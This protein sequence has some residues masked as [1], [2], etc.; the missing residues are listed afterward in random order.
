MPLGTEPVGKT[1]VTVGFDDTQL[2]QGLTNL[3]A[4][5]KLADNTWK[6]SLSTF[7]QSDRSIEKLSTSV[8]GMTDKLEI[9][10]KIVDAHK[11][12]VA[13]LTKEYG[14]NHTKVIKANA[15][16]AKQQGVYG[17]LKRSINEMTAEMK[18]QTIEQKKAEGQQA[19]LLKQEQEMA[20]SK[21]T[22]Q[23][24]MK[25]V[26]AEWQN[27]VSKMKLAGN[28]AG[29]YEGKIK[30]LNDK[31]E[32][33]K[34]AVYAQ[35]AE[36]RKLTKEYG[37]NS[38]K[39]VKANTELKNQ[40]KIM[41]DLKGDIAATT[42]ELQDFNKAEAI[43]SSPW[44]QRQKEFEA[45][46]SKL[47]TAGDRLTST[48]QN[49][50]MAV[51]APLAGIGAMGVKT[52]M[53]FDA[54]MSRVGAIS[55]TTGTKFEEMKRVAME[56]GASTTKSASEV[57]K[58]MEEMAAKGY[59]ANQ[60]MAAM[61]GIISAAEASGSDM[62]QTANVMASAMN[63]F[64]IEADKSNHVADVLAQTAN[65]SAADITDME[66]ALKYAAAPAKSLGM[67]LEETSASIGMMVDAGLKGEQAGT[68][69]RGALLGLL[70][71]SEA[72]SKLMEKMG[73]EITDASG[74]FIGM[75]QLVRNLEKSMVGMTDTQKAANLS[76]LVGKEAVSG[77]L[78][79]MDQGP[80]RIGKMTKSLEESDGAS[81]KASKSMMDNLKGAVEEMSG[82][83]E[84]VGIQ[85]G[86]DMTPTI[87]K[88][89]DGAQNLATKFSEMPDW[90]RKTAV[91]IGLVAAATG[92]T[93]VGV[94][95]VAKATGTV[96]DGLAKLTGKYAANTLAAEGNALAN[97]TV[98][99]SLG[100]NG[101]LNKGIGSTLGNFL[102]F[103]KNAE[104][105]TKS[106]G[107]LSRA[108][109]LLTRGLGLIGGPVGLAITAGITAI[110][111]G[112]KYAYDH[113]DWF[114]KGVDNTIWVV[115]NLAGE[116]VDGTKKIVDTVA[117]WE[118]VKKT[119][120]V[121]SGA[122]DYAKEHY[123]DFIGV[124]KKPVD[125]WWGGL[126]KGFTW[127]NN[128]VDKSGGN[129][130]QFK[131]NY[132]KASKEWAT[133]TLQ[134][135]KAGFNNA[136][137]GSKEWLTDSGQKMKSGLIKGQESVK[138]WAQ[139]F[140]PNFKTWL[141]NSK[142]S[143]SKWGEETAD[144]ISSGLNAGQST[145]K[146]WAEDFGPTFSTWLSNSKTSLSK[147]GEETAGKISSGLN[148]GQSTVK[149]W[150]EDFGP[151]AKGWLTT[152]KSSL[153]TWGQ[154]TSGRIASGME[155]G[156]KT[157][158]QWAEDTGS[159]I[160]GW[161]STSKKSIEDWGAKLPG[162]IKTAYTNAKNAI[163]QWRDSQSKENVKFYMPIL[164][165][166][167]DD[168]KNFP[169]KLNEYKEGFKSSVSKFFSGVFG[170]QDNKGGGPLSSWSSS[171]HKWFT[172]LPKVF[173]ERKEAVKTAV[174][175][176]FN[177][178]FA[179]DKE[180][181]GPMKSW[182]SGV[183]KWFSNIPTLFNQK[184]EAAKTAVSNFFVRAGQGITDE[185]QGM[186]SWSK[187]IKDW[188]T[189][190]PGRI[191]ASFNTIKD[192]VSKSISGIF[193]PS[194]ADMDA[195]SAKFGSK[196]KKAVTKPFTS[197]E[198]KKDFSDK[199]GEMIVDGAGYAIGFA[200]VALLATGRE[201][202]KR[203]AKGMNTS[204]EDSLIGGPLKRFFEWVPK[205]FAGLVGPASKGAKD[206][207]KGVTGW[208]NST[209]KDGM[210]AV[211]DLY[212][213]T[214][215]KFMD[216]KDKAVGNAK[217]MWKGVTGWFNSTKKDGMKA[218]G[219]LYTR[220]KDKFVDSKDK[221]VSNA[222][223]MWKGVTGWFASTSKE[224]GK[225]TGKIYE[226]TKDNFKLSMIYAVDK[227]K[228]L[229]KGVT[230]WFGD[231]KD[232]AIS[233]FEKAREKVV[234]K[235]EGMY[236]GAK[237]WI[238][239]IGTFISNSVE[240]LKT[241]ASNL[242]KNVANGA[243][244]GLNG[245]I[246][247]INSITQKIMDKSLLSKIPLLSTGTGSYISG[248]AI[249]KDTPA[250]VGDRGPGNG[251]GGFRR[252]IIH[253]AD[254]S[255]HL[256]PAKDTL[257]HLNK[258]DRVYSGAQTHHML[259]GNIPRFNKGSDESWWGKAGDIWNSGKKLA[260]DVWNG[261]VGKVIDGAKYVGKI[262]GDIFDYIENPGKL[263]DMVIGNIGSV[264]GGVGGIT[265][266][267]GTAA[268]SKIKTALVDKVKGWLE[269]FGGGNADGGEILSYPLTTPYSPNARPPGYPFNAHH[270][271][272]DLGTKAGTLL[273]APTSGVLSQVNDYNGGLVAM[274]KDKIYTQFFMHLS[275]VLK[276][277]HV[278]QGEAIVK[279]GNS[280]HMTTGDHLHYQV[281]KNDGT[282]NWN[283]NTIDPIKF[284]QG[285]A[286]KGGP[287]GV[288]GNARS[289][290]SSIIKAA[291]QMKQKIS[292]VDVNNIIA[293]I[294]RES[295]GNQSVVQGNI[296]DINNING[297][298][299]RGL[300][301]YVPST[302][303][304]YAV[305]GYNNINNGY[306]QLLA[307][308]NNT[309]WRRDN[310][311]G[312][313]GW[314]PSG[315]RRFAN[316]G[317]IQNETV[318]A[319]EE[320]PEMIIPLDPKK[321]HRARP[322]LE[323]ANSIVHGDN[324]I[325][326]STGTTKAKSSASKSYGTHNIVWGDT[327]WD[328]AR[329]F[330][331]TVAELK[332]LNG[333]N[334]DLI[335]AGRKLKVP[336]KTAATVNV[337]VQQ[338]KQKPSAYVRTNRIGVLDSIAD[339][340]MAR[341]KTT[342]FS[343]LSKSYGAI[344]S[345]INSKLKTMKTDAP[346]T[347]LKNVKSIVSKVDSTLKADEKKLKTN[348]ANLKKYATNSKK[349]AQIRAES[350]AIKNQ[351]Q[352]LQSV[353]KKELLKGDVL[354]KVVKQRAMLSASM[355]DLQ[356]KN[357]VLKGEKA[358]LAGSVRDN[359]KGYAGF[360]AVSGHSTSDFL[361][362][363][364]Y[365]LRRMQEFHNDLIKLRKMGLDPGILREL[366]EGGVENSY[367]KAKVLLRGGSTGV[368]AINAM[369][370]KINKLAVSMGLSESGLVYNERI[371]KQS[372]QLRSLTQ[373]RTALRTHNDRYMN[374]KV[375]KMRAP[376]PA[377]RLKS[378]SSAQR[379]EAASR[380][381]THQ[382]VT[383]AK[384]LN[385]VGKNDKY[386]HELEKTINRI[387]NDKVKSND[388]VIADLQKEMSKQS[389]N[390]DKVVELMALILH[391]N[392]DVIM[393]GDKVTKKVDKRQAVNAKTNARRRTS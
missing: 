273:H 101:K 37:E 339:N 278:K 55:D 228:G 204:V 48:G 72:N 30:S 337:K 342:K 338:P 353:K 386:A 237:S 235:F 365:R 319:G 256:T 294:Q 236:K 288:S 324:L 280:G 364:R 122:V 33:Q 310:P 330:K 246:G 10:T 326:L 125:L 205:K 383:T 53:D 336:G 234:G 28:Q 3:N 174:S 74:N 357:N 242:G 377:P 45:F 107:L 164:K 26:D 185:G 133:N 358:S 340:L 186:S 178:V 159:K 306:H 233:L 261:T 13:N 202:I 62:T 99:T 155:S 222:K 19:K 239:L 157:I 161:L 35:A 81:Q 255:M 293:Q 250:I 283:T 362:V 223:L 360:S 90:A 232:D 39:A 102:Q 260:G 8:K 389:K 348:A 279:T 259:N 121:V 117:N 129:W 346:E 24:K 116:W 65:Q 268:F 318:I 59:D 216:S 187:R 238:T 322:L 299:A 160:G 83:F 309:N 254:G 224:V 217:L 267:I 127:F 392:I 215:D 196:A 325:K 34:K 20:R 258:G 156:K 329:T 378:L 296:G 47:Q 323:Q 284:L 154:E 369:Q 333:L 245:M 12:K 16:L 334:S 46:S 38:E 128:I 124:L 58:G 201:I 368:K 275:S 140:G 162:Q 208:F 1:V 114:K 302:F 94:G 63:A 23:D 86:Q 118:P 388:K 145:V 244:S 285:H 103:G 51:T 149:K 52:A 226:D 212:T 282:N 315:L 163:T 263:V 385:V 141:S 77:M 356:S 29:I 269:D 87:E 175:N 173:D 219:D 142:T 381:A 221:A 98:G 179:G 371:N 390:M 210:K 193:N 18:Q 135:I 266:K 352:Y 271:G 203:L 108:G 36:V 332:R 311:A 253:R 132:A 22:L 31:L 200:A 194:Q 262:A 88:L 150:A 373:K 144:K 32:L 189:S 301:Q 182:S 85:I 60:I 138:Q 105:A 209:K 363:M 70:S 5:M 380:A 281:R 241:K 54:Q 109:G 76:Q 257:V 170:N 169:N 303:A 359:I 44:T 21:A 327:L 290:S 305:K 345:L 66:F 190:L 168:I 49:M 42:K 213:R 264:F 331:T 56:L 111:V 314:G 270:Y 265:G 218:V 297:T 289:W 69:L 366:I 240:G 252:E 308:F 374:S 197:K 316:G 123:D 251:P 113:V 15:D 231:T 295:N 4:Q 355:K 304:N 165:G 300:L 143:L 343:S 89:A 248:G 82:A 176:F 166:M 112:F 181:A 27:N 307:F 80:D 75:E 243:I 349:V 391:K 292:Q 328:L 106:V 158:K 180:T 93:I 61:P 191:S 286:P 206:M 73:I 148:A 11:Q 247:G 211:G 298:P 40:S 92:P 370:T 68:T 25:L 276:S 151:K 7:K 78:V 126:E 57:A 382:I 375:V 387:K 195:A 188:F 230:G 350:A 2:K 372:A 312:R 120:E 341:S 199:L 9:Q 313:S 84:T 192:S 104:K 41:N 198:N 96:V 167:M 97:A 367:G 361:S 220:T 277:G 384:R 376:N 287:T 131:I 79:M 110:G 274:L 321:R 272:I 320:Y 347:V 153:Y 225:K 344:G 6:A 183:G 134:D 100:K 43:K 119:I 115:K 91:G 152:T 379:R 71:P 67:S 207:W 172:N 17:N 50:S 393:D 171:V 214:K 249:A 184:K 354:T 291:A 95:L 227:A 136:V 14:E 351:M 229:W 147:W 130:E 317:I 137:Q 335:I 177:G 146:K 139:D 64:G